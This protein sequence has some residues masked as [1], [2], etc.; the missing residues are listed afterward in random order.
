MHLR[1]SVTIESFSFV[2]DLHV[3]WGSSPPQQHIL[4]SSC[5]L[6]CHGGKI[7]IMGAQSPF[8]PCL[9]SLALQSWVNAI[10][11]MTHFQD[12]CPRNIV[13]VASSSMKSLKASLKRSFQGMGH[14]DLRL[15]LVWEGRMP[16]YP[17]LVAC[18]DLL[19]TTCAYLWVEDN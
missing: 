9:R 4:P 13:K 16:Y 11:T 2:L 3:R 12:V 15:T 6:C 14:S 8:M 1:Q 10:T 18:S 17:D 7:G 5:N 19:A